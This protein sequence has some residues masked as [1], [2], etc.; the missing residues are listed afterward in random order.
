MI[1]SVLSKVNIPRLYP[2]KQ[3]FMRP[4][5]KD[6]ED[7]L[8]QKLSAIS[9]MR[10]QTIAITAG[11]RGITGYAELINVIAS[12]VRASGAVPILVPAMG[13]HGG[14]TFSGQKQVLSKL[15]ITEE[16]AEIVPGGKTIK[17]GINA[18]GN[19][20]NVCSKFLDVD[21]V[22][23]LNR[24]KPHTSFR[25]KYESGIVKMAA[26]GMGGHKGASTTHAAGFMSMADNIVSAAKVIFSKINLVAAV[27]TVENAYGDIA[28]LEVLLKDEILVKESTLLE[29]AKELMPKLPSD[30]IDVLIVD[31]IGKDISGTGMDT[32]IIGRYH[33]KAASGGPNI[34]KIVVLGL[35]QKSG[36]NANGIGLADFTTNRLY[37]QIDFEATNLNVL[38][39][40]E[41]ASAKVPPV[42]Q[43]DELAIKAAL[44]ICNKKDYEEIKVVRIKNTKQLENVLVS[45]NLL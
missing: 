20:I 36:G 38:T 21:G 34:N 31:E 29:K 16:I 26:I 39:S 15:G 30:E 28:E 18:T 44:Y 4:V 23:M 25:G 32:N 37:E 45:K 35:S 41:P 9:I 3:T 13:S 33:T 19:P 10:G 1:D 8:K 14:G 7:V 22:I 17:L 12:H 43:S 40:T 2:L 5:L 42:M 27:A 6:F 11:S 24:I